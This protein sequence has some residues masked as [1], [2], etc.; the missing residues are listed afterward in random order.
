MCQASNP[1]FPGSRPLCRADEPPDSACTSRGWAG[2]GPGGPKAQKSSIH[3]SLLE[4]KKILIVGHR[5]QIISIFI[6]FFFFI[7]AVASAAA[8]AAAAVAAA[9]AAAAM[10]AARTKLEKKKLTGRRNSAGDREKKYLKQTW[11]WTS[12]G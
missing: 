8:S 2:P 11:L 5:C 10:A 1:R 6:L 7:V 9:V 3:S 4:S 12:R